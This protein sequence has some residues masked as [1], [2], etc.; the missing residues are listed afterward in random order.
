MSHYKLLR[1]VDC[2]MHIVDPQIKLMNQIHQAE[3]VTR[4]IK[5][6]ITCARLLNI[7][8]IANT[9]YL[10]GLGPY[11]D[12]L[13]EIVEDIPRP[14]KMEFGAY[15]NEETRTLVTSLSDSISTV[16]MVGVETHIC[17]YQTAVGVL[18]QGLT[19]W[20][21]TDGTSSRSYENH[22]LGLERLRQLG[23]IV[24][25]AEMLVYELL[26][27]AGTPQFKELLPHIVEFSKE[28]A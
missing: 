3:R 21:V 1:P 10:K 23:A 28:E 5:F 12:E 4:V 27:K 25:P 8:M 19:P 9:Q 2:C 17:I 22:Q 24:G 16:I 6:M 26:G 11:V 7:P 18:Q 14:D 15:Q 20:I 13:E